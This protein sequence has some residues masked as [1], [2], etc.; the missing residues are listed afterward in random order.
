[1]VVFCKQKTAYEIR[2]SDWSSDVCSS[3]LSARSPCIQAHEIS[4]QSGYTGAHRARHP[5]ADD[6]RH[7]TV[8][9][10]LHSGWR[11]ATAGRAGA[12]TV[13]PQPRAGDRHGLTTGLERLSG[14][15]PVVQRHRRVGRPLRRT[16]EQPSELESLMRISYAVLGLK[17]KKTT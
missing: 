15:V 1:M 13:W 9:R 7:R 8:D 2:I 3:D 16:E 17:K 12:L 10:S 4:G 14:R 11:R 6:G 5:R